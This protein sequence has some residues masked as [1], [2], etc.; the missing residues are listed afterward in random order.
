MQMHA[1]LH[2]V[3][4]AECAAADEIKAVLLIVTILVNAPAQ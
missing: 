3:T 1:V 4:G 2:E